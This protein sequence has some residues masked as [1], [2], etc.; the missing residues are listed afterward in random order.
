MR[1][2]MPGRIA[3]RK[4][5]TDQLGRFTAESKKRNTMNQEA[6]G[7]GGEPEAMQIRVEKWERKSRLMMQFAHQ[8]SWLRT[9]RVGAE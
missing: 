4:Q 5:T 7:K 3:S 1:P 2:R 8:E 6:K 9:W